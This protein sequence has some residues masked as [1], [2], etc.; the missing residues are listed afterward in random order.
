MLA[1]CTPWPEELAARYRA[2]GYWRG[3]TFSGVLDE[4]IARH[5]ERLAIV[6]DT[7]RWSYRELGAEADRLARG[8]HALGLG[9]N[10]RVVVQL[11]NCAEFFAVIFALFRLGALPIFALP[12]HRKF[13]IGHFCQHAQATAYVIADQHAGFDYRTLA[14]EVQAD[15]PCLRHVLVLGEAGEFRALDA[16]PRLEQDLPAPPRPGDTAFFQLSGG[17]T[18][19]PK[20]IPRTHDDYLY[21]VRASAHICQLSTDSVYLSVIPAGHNFALSSPGSLGTLYAGGTVVMC[22]HP[23]PDVALAWIARERVTITALVPPLV[24]VWL[25]AIH[26]MRPDLRSLQVVQVG[27]ARLGDDLAQ[28]LSQELDVTLQQVFGMAEGLVNYTRLDDPLGV[29]LHSQ[30]RPISPDD[31][32]RIVDDEDQP[33]PPGAVGHLLTRGPYTIRGYYKADEHNRRAFTAEGFYRTGDLVRCTAQGNLVVEGRAKDQINR[34]GEKISAEEVEQ[35][36]LAHAAVSACA[37]VAMPD[38][39][40]GEKS[41]AFVVRKDAT[42]RGIDLIRF[43]RARGLAT[44]KIPDR[45]EFVD[46]LAHT[47]VGK[48]NKKQLRQD[49]A[50]R[51]GGAAPGPQHPTTLESTQP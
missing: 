23:S 51:L 6:S 10:D 8:F 24:P 47:G 45:I 15:T 27:G 30:G 22:A 12:P 50:A 29:V 5:G 19:T 21:S 49:I 9:P 37:I 16:L 20:L 39:F 42:V 41:C 1:H 11:P 2:Q 7:R 36:L 28:R 14:R 44:Y 31:E 43:L 33:V 3:E 13:E 4:R 18:G 46:Q 26:R 40:L 25:D 35:Q 34:G 38:A 32:I 17:S 48:I